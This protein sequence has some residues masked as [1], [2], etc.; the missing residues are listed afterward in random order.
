[1]EKRMNKNLET[2]EYP[3]QNR[4]LFKF[5]ENYFYADCSNP[6]F[7]CNYFYH[8]DSAIRH[9]ESVSYPSP[10]LYPHFKSEKTELNCFFDKLRINIQKGDLVVFNKFCA[11]YEVRK[12]FYARYDKNYLPLKEF[13]DAD[14]LTYVNFSNALCDVYEKTECLGYLST[15]MKCCD[16]LCSISFG[17]PDSEELLIVLK[18][19][20][21]YVRNL[22]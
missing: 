17:Y 18:K 12:K 11:K 10:D 5:P 9:L 14:H 15:L 1:M 16:A 3:Y 8:R 7:G 21:E 20:M 2:S 4:D 6:N 22:R 13:G 19:E